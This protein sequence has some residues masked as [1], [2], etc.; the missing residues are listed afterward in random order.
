MKHNVPALLLLAFI[1]LVLTAC[2]PCSEEDLFTKP[3]QTDPDNHSLVTALR[4]TLK[5]NYLAPCKP[6]EYI[7]NLWT[8]ATNGVM[9]DT[10]FGG[11][12]GSSAYDW[13]P[14]VDLTPGEAYIWQVAAKN[15]TITSPYSP[16]WE[17]I[18][19]P[20]CESES[21]LAPDPVDPIS[22][23]INTLDPTY[24]WDYSD[25][26]CTP[27][28]YSLQ[29]SPNSNLTSPVIN[30][31]ETNPIKAWTP[32]VTLND[33]D[34]YYWRV[35][36]LEG[37]DDGPWSTVESFRTNAY[38]NCICLVA[39]LETPILV[40]P[41]AYEIIPD[42]QPILDWTFPGYCEVEGFAVHLSEEQD[43]SV[44]SLFGG[45]GNSD[46][47]WRSDELEPGMQYWWEIAAGVGTDFGEFS[48]PRSFF[49]G[50]ECSP[51]VGIAAP[52]LL[53][54]INGE[55]VTEGY[56]K[57]RYQP[58][59][60]RCIPDGYFINLQTDPAFAGENLLGVGE[61]FLPGTTLLTEELEDCRIHFWKA[62][63]IQGGV[64][65]P[66]SLPEWFY[67]NQSGD[68][69]APIGPMLATPVRDL[70]CY[71]GPGLHYPK[72]GGFLLMGEWTEV[73][74]RNRFGT[75]LALTDLD[76]FMRCWV[77]TE[78]TKPT[79]DP[80]G[81]P[82]LPDPEIPKEQE[83][84]SSGP[85]CTKDISDPVECRKA[86]GTWVPTATNAGYC[87]CP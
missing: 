41:A 8:N 42:L 9:T 81:V 46:T 86:G 45:T 71:F 50:P 12:T 19:G 84:P 69:P 27:E 74:G 4:P 80:A 21:L 70:A 54:P 66:E 83:R 87:R 31:R 14:S 67:T 72:T 55:V 28:G 77:P 62:A 47:N 3:E 57:L 75:W 61:Y 60:P 35:A 20:A 49:T 56:A 13:S 26:D 73:L 40:Y 33:C 1:A 43:F 24:I 22:G 48:S 79:G 17:F 59:E 16:F 6:T 29:V 65:G 30:L 68:C 76:G 2:G 23:S 38:G 53:S 36:A 18:V 7:I 15:G 58:G 82:E 34:W 85:V 32:G 63:V 11:V 44:T 5:W 37:V 78:D 64:H 39:E 52:E 51:F 10:G 25:P